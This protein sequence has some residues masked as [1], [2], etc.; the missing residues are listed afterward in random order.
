MRGVRSVDH[1]F[2]A[3]EKSPFR[4]RFRLQ[5][6]ERLYLRQ[7]TLSAVLQHAVTLSLSGSLPRSRQTTASKLRVEDTRFSSPSTP[8]PCVAGRALQSGTAF[9]AGMHSLV[10]K[11]TLSWRCWSG[12]SCSNG[13]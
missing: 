1:I 13:I 2:E 6:R 4:R 12:G 9:Q 10:R 3:L 11:W 5:E 8:P 7:K